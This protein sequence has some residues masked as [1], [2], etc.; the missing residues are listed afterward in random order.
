VGI[1]VD[2][3]AFVEKYEQTI[4]YVFILCLREG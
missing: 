3:T 2:A 1:D 4:I